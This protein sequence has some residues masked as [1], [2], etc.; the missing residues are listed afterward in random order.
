MFELL[1]SI[2]WSLLK[3]G[4]C[5]EKPIIGVLAAN[6]SE[7]FLCFEI[8]LILEV[9]LSEGKS[10]LQFDFRIAVELGQCSERIDFA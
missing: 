3:K 2:G 4:E 6:A 7:S 10:L 5:R 1:F 9:H 8:P